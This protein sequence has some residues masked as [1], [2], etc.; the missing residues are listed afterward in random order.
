MR[1]II[2][3]VFLFL[4]IFFLS[5]CGKQTTLTPAVDNSAIILFYGQE[6]SHCQIVEKYIADNK[7]K[8]KV[9]FSEREVNHDQA[10]AELMLKKQETCTQFDKNN[11]GAVP[12]LW[13]ADKCYIGQDEIRQFFKE[14]ANVKE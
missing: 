1:K 12:F 6:C 3:G 9:V 11:I 7:I 8:E 4:G 13:T 5:G 10:N 14:K 2:L